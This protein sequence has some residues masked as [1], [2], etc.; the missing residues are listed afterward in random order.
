MCVDVIGRVRRNLSAQ[1]PRSRGLRFAAVS[2][3]LRDVDTPSVLLIRRA[4]RPGDPWSG[5]IAFPGGKAQPED[6]SVKDT[7]V[8]ETVEEVGFD[9]SRT[10]EFLGYGALATTHTGSMDVVP[11]VFALKEVV[12]VKPNEEVS[13]YRWVEMKE[14]LAAEAQSTYQREFGG[15]IVGVPAYTVGDYIV[16]GLTHRIL[17]SLLKV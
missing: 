15:E 6:R 1:E 5:H 4:E 10:A 14:L 2:V 7:A 16:W 9:L 3:I 17:G 11:L 13:S 12:E 8:R